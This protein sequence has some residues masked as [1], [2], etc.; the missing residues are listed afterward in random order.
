MTEERVVNIVFENLQDRPLPFDPEQL[1]SEVAACV[2]EQEGCP[3]EAEVSLTLTDDDEIR[4]MNRMHREIDAATDVL[5]F[6]MVPF[7][8]P[9]EYDFLETADDCFDPDTGLLLL[10]DIV[11]SA[12]HVFTQADAYGHSLRREFAF[13]AAHSMLHL[14]G[15]DHMTEAEARE[16]EAKQEQALAFLGITR[17]VT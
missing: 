15:Y 7:E 12:D 11:I 4:K 14:L 17:D 8:R 1:A 6:P 2:L 13:L 16:M 5:S 10:G 3:Y 9:A